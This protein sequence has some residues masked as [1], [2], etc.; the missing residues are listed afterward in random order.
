MDILDNPV[1]R[2]KLWG[3][4]Y[5]WREAIESHGELSRHGDG[6]FVVDPEKGIWLRAA[7][8]RNAIYI[9][10]LPKTCE[11]HAL[12]VIAKNGL[13]ASRHDATLR[14]APAYA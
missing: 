4:S 14:V 10:K 1:T 3:Q 12:A 6:Q 8:K 11:A 9:T 2:G 13:V 7:G 5:T